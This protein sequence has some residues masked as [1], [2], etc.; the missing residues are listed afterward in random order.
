M[1]KI[2]KSS[3]LDLLAENSRKT[4]I[5]R[6]ENK[7][8]SKEFSVFRLKNKLNEHEKEWKKLFI[9]KNDEKY[10]SLE[11]SIVLY[12]SKLEEMAKKSIDENL[13]NIKSSFWTNTLR[14]NKQIDD[15]CFPK[16]HVKTLHSEGVKAKGFSKLIS[17]TDWIQYKD[18]EGFK[19]K[20]YPQLVR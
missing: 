13:V 8:L 1:K 20:N 12:Q 19:F 16:R 3:W 17:E 2:Q 11:K 14:N 4:S 18:D 6:C 9:N 15:I 10:P 5:K 7:K